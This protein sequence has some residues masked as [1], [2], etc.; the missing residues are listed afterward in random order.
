MHTRVG[1]SAKVARFWP[2]QLLNVTE[3][4]YIYQGRNLQ[5]GIGQ[6][7]LLLTINN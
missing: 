5:I 6:A 1:G 2:L 4:K 3:L 7:K